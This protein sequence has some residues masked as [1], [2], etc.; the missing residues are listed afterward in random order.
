MRRPVGSLGGESACRTWPNALR[1]AGRMSPLCTRTPTPVLLP[2][3]S[4]S[5]R[6]VDMT[7]HS[8]TTTLQALDALSASP[9]SSPCAKSASSPSERTPAQSLYL[10]SLS[11]DPEAMGTSPSQRTSWGP[12]D[13]KPAGRVPASVLLP[14]E[15]GSLDA[16][17]LEGEVDQEEKDVYPDGGMEVR[18]MCFLR[19][20]S[21]FRLMTRRSITGMDRCRRSLLR[22]AGGL[23]DDSESSLHSIAR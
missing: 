18:E 11:F 16:K 22:S 12:T 14:S 9:P 19:T 6:H 21:S 7:P 2:H 17:V 5:S 15:K 20:G 3:L 13:Q 8:S 4:V 23:W 10:Q 1:R